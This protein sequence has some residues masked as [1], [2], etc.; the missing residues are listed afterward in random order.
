M[1]P[2]FPTNGPPG[3]DLP[4]TGPASAPPTSPPTFSPGVAPGYVPGPPTAP[5]SGSL[6]PPTTGPFDPTVAQFQPS[7]ADSRNKVRPWWGLGDVFLGVGFILLLAIIGMVAALFIGAAT[8]E[9]ELDLETFG[10]DELAT[11]GLVIVIGGGAQQLGQ[12]LWPLIVGRWKGFGAAK[13]FGFRFKLVDLPLG[14][15]TGV[16]ALISAG[17]I[18]FGLSWLLGIDPEAADNTGFL[19]DNT[20]SPWIWGLVFITVIGAPFSEE[21]LFRGL[22]LRA[23]EKRATWVSGLV[24]SSIIFA[25]VHYQ[26]GMGRSELAVLLIAIGAAGTLFGAIAIKTGRLGAPIIGHMLFNGAAVLSILA[27]Q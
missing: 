20:D 1:T 15:A 25:L 21:L 5:P 22:L 27:T 23:L 6:P 14:I 10:G 3:N 24:G 17:L 26:P 2:G 4:R 19:T 9:F 7:S 12:F 13:D 18:N 11:S 8:G 16:V